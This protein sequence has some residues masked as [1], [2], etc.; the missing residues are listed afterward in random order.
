M[1]TVFVA[2]LAIPGSP[3]R[4]FQVVVTQKPYYNYNQTCA[5]RAGIV[6]RIMGYKRNQ[7][8]FQNNSHA[9][10]QLKNELRNVQ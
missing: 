2:R 6:S 10:A 8:G 7:G 1:A 5:H 9:V 4:S 3:H